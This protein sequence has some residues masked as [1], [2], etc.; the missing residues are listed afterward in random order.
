M[1]TRRSPVATFNTDPN[2]KNWVEAPLLTR[3]ANIGSKQWL[4]QS[5]CDNKNAAAICLTFS[6]GEETMESAPW[7]DHPS[8]T[9]N[10]SSLRSPSQLASIKKL[11]PSV[12]YPHASSYNSFRPQS[13]M[14]RHN[15]TSGYACGDDIA[16]SIRLEQT[17]ISTRNEDSFLSETSNEQNLDEKHSH[18]SI[19]S[20]MYLSSPDGFLSNSNSVP[21]DQTDTK[22]G[23]N[24][25]SISI[26]TNS[27]LSIGTGALSSSN[28]KL[29]LQMPSSNPLEDTPA[30]EVLPYAQRLSNS[31]SSSGETSSNA[32]SI[33]ETESKESCQISTDDF[34]I[35]ASEGIQTKQ[36]ASWT[37][38]PSLID[39]T[40]NTYSL[41][42]ELALLDGQETSYLS[43][44]SNGSIRGRIQ[45]ERRRTLRFIFSTT[46][47]PVQE[48]FRRI[49]IEQQR[50]LQKS[51]GAEEST[52]STIDNMKHHLSIKST[53]QNDDKD[54]HSSSSSC[55]KLDSSSKNGLDTTT[56][57]TMTEDTSY[58]SVCS[59]STGSADELKHDDDSSTSTI[60]TSNYYEDTF[61]NY[62]LQ[63]DNPEQKNK[64]RRI[65]LF[66]LIPLLI[67]TVVVLVCVP[68]F[69]KSSRNI[70]TPTTNFTAPNSD[71]TSSE[72]TAL[73]DK[74]VD[75][76]SLL[77]MTISNTSDAMSSSDSLLMRK[78]CTG[79]SLQMHRLPSFFERNTSL[80][81]NEH[82]SPA[83][84]EDGQRIALSAIRRTLSVNNATDSNAYCIRIY[85]AT[86]SN[87]TDNKFPMSWNL[88]AE[89]DLDAFCE[90]L[91]PRLSLNKDGSIVM[92]A[93]ELT[94]AFEVSMYRLENTQTASTNAS[95]QVFSSARN[96]KRPHYS[97]RSTIEFGG[98]RLLNSKNNA[99]NETPKYSWSV[100]GEQPLVVP[101]AKFISLSLSSTGY[102]LAVAKTFRPQGST[103]SL[104]SV[105]VFD[106]QNTTDSWKNETVVD[107]KTS[108]TNPDVSVILSAD[109][110][111]L[112]LNGTSNN[113]NSNTTSTTH[114]HFYGWNSSLN[115]WKP[116]PWMTSSETNINLFSNDNGT[117]WTDESIC[118]SLDE[119]IITRD[120]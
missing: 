17:L 97:N 100:L 51:D 72:E 86:N 61:V 85:E 46:L 53:S 49:I 18:S 31:N 113:S 25:S 62:F 88:I 22:G 103:L 108:Y 37:T 39:E 21:D 112:A 93:I 52:G 92:V 29:S 30:E 7:C 83:L 40:H 102:R 82:F 79:Y 101:N 104:G 19:T 90:P 23:C 94:T 47:P 1:S 78:N 41:T 63:G 73:V 13:M 32:N 65:L 57:I 111:I 45:R 80:F 105:I 14:M 120:G 115:L 16:S 77:P 10:E 70:S 15:R 75:E 91:K 76:G 54:G 28:E 20:A 81:R 44:Q 74:S 55:E 42:A 119:S 69:K 11:V 3:D 116:K 96:K 110:D 107:F 2:T 98:T 36:D 68:Y 56:C 35:G 67:A 43:K 60:R 109:G 89:L 118:L 27:G 9:S 8:L 99:T 48:E 87:D 33:L 58:R 117:S 12:D 59:L 50:P 95:S 5:D 24:C 26:H 71:I 114:V 106:Y 38:S 84:S 66:I 4:S 64:V 6:S 34:E